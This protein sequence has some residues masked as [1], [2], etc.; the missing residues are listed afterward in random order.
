MGDYLG[1]LFDT[2]GFP[3]RWQCGAWTPGH[4]WLHILS[5]VGIWA[6]Y[7]AIP[8]VLAY[9]LL[10]RRLPF[11]GVQFLFI[12]FILS[13]GLT[14]LIEA[15]IFW[16]PA[17]RLAGVVKLFTAVVSWLT[18]FALIRVTPK[19][20]TLRA[21]TELEAEITDRKRAEGALRESEELFRHAFEH[22]AIGKA[23]V[24]PDG[25]WLRV[26]RSLCEMLGY[27]EAGFLATDFQR[28]THPDDLGTDLEDVWG[29]LNET[30]HRY[31]TQKRYL[32]RSGRVVNVELAVS[33]VR[34]AAGV[35]QYFI[36]QVSDVTARVAAQE[37]LRTS[38]REKETLLKE[39][40]HRVKNNLQVV[41]TLLDLQSGHTADAGAREMFRESRGRVRS[42]ALIH[43]RLY[44]SDD[45][46][47]VEFAA[48]ARQLTTDLGRAY[49]VPGDID[50]SVEAGET[51]MPLDTAIPCGLLLN[52]LVSNALK[53]AFPRGG[54]GEVRVSLTTA[55]GRTVLRVA[56]TG[57]GF[58]AGVDFRST[59]SF[60]LQ[61]IHTL[62]EQLS[63]TVSLGR[64]PGT[65]FV[66][67]FPTG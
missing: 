11:R 54:P 51:P 28:I 25:R 52:E 1:R 10:R 56:D 38:L 22:A 55:G 16:W 17:Y 58:P 15:L 66:V 33:L 12:A 44:R 29:L 53:H 41:S 30:A 59:Q 39:I 31:Q 64:G 61:L 62:A 48:S 19:I 23:L 13:C 4:G 26:N 50:L 63:G 60:G 32:H 27:D 21:S 20:M 8:L 40:H 47:R 6:A 35:P 67:E 37:Q 18:V 9:Y 7:S 24:A 42:M 46:A 34:D 3:P 2:S 43:E 14:H 5:D 45:L 36:I 57:V 49:K 65:T